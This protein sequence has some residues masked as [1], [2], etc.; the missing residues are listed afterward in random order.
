MTNPIAE[1]VRTAFEQFAALLAERT[2]MLPLDISGEGEPVVSAAQV[3][4]HQ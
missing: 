3:A 4:K 1:F 2:R